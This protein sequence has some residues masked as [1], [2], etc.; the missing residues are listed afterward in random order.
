MKHPY[1]ILKTDPFKILVIP[2]PVRERDL[3]P[4][5]KRIK[6]KHGEKDERRKIEQIDH[7]AA[8]GKFVEKAFFRFPRQ[9]P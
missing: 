5:Q 9:R 4:F 7:C 1:V 6:N 3:N 2:V 8:A